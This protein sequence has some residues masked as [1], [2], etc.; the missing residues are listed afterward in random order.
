[1]N[2]TIHLFD[3][4]LKKESCKALLKCKFKLEKVF[5]DFLKKEAIF[6]KLNRS[7]LSFTLN[8]TLCGKAK[9]RSVNREYR[10]KDRATDV[11]SFPLFH[12][13]RKNKVK[14][15]SPDF[16]FLMGEVMIGDILICKEVAMS[17]SQEFNISLRDELIH[18]L[19]HGFLHLLGFDHEVSK[20]AE[21]IME[22][23][24]SEL[25][26]KIAKELKK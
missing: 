8:V 25:I 7:D 9:M 23:F 26:N 20:K 3:T 12:E 16:K 6:S 10:G 24:E 19:C 5:V 17:Q 2:L 11:L 18:L 13:L 1:M 21:E 4:G 15:S 22:K 14:I